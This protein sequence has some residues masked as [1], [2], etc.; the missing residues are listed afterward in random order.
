MS[1]Y[2]WAYVMIFGVAL[3]CTTLFVIARQ[4]NKKALEK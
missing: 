3:V 2:F 1:A 4:A